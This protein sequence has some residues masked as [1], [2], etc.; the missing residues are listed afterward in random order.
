M[1]V[2]CNNE[3]LLQNDFWLGKT[4]RINYYEC[5]GRILT[6]INFRKTPSFLRRILL[7]SVAS[8]DVPYFYTLSH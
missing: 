2:K 8:L 6:L 7:S 4:V 5:V 3:A 1:Y